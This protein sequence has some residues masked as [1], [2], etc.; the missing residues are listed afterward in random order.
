MASL[1]DKFEG[2]I[3]NHI[4]IFLALATLRN[5]ES[6]KAGNFNTRNNDFK[7]QYPRI[8]EFILNI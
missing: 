5:V 7:K 3:D 6:F 1:R 8:L 2:M 4:S